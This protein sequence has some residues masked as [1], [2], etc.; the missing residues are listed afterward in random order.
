MLWPNLGKHA[1]W[2]CNSMDQEWTHSFLSRPEGRKS[3]QNTSRNGFSARTPLKSG[4]CE[5]VLVKR[6]M[7]A[8]F[9]FLTAF[10]SLQF[11]EML[12]CWLKRLPQP[13]KWLQLTSS[14]KVPF[15]GVLAQ[16]LHLCLYLAM[17]WPWLEIYQLFI[18]ADKADYCSRAFQDT[19]SLLKK[20]LF[21][22]NWQSSREPRYL[23]RRAYP[24]W[25]T[26]C[27]Q[28]SASVM[29]TTYKQAT[30]LH[31]RMS[32]LFSSAHLKLIIKYIY[33]QTF[34]YPRGCFSWIKRNYWIYAW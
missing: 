26:F 32:N 24:T 27:L 2:L 14:Y 12:N 20:S 18:T 17:L 15:Y 21:C 23:Q 8:H 29:F 1:V 11:A 16:K 6:F 33:M 19:E 34:P 5:F 3:M 7:W 9:A 10:I 4:R 31:G 30:S 13:K 22:T 28:R 25:K